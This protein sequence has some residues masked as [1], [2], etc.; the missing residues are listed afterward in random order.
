MQFFFIVCQA[1]GYRNILKLSSRHL[2]LPH[3][4][5]FQK[6]KKDLELVSLPHF[7]HKF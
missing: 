4:K 6:T 2:S 1:E 3:I 5:L 7:L